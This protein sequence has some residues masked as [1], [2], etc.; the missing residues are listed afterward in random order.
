MCT[1]VHTHTHVCIPQSYKKCGVSWFNRLKFGYE[2]LGGRSISCVEQSLLVGVWC[3]GRGTGSQ[4]H[5]VSR[6]CCRVERSKKMKSQILK[7]TCLAELARPGQQ[8]SNLLKE[9][10][11]VCKQL[12][13]L[14]RV[15]QEAEGGQRWIPEM[16]IHWETTNSAL[17][18]LYLG[19]LTLEVMKSCY[20][21]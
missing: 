5:M 18:L 2:T 9:R 15:E 7:R 8:E 6:L 19:L 21:I 16:E 12:V 11:R 14:K 17:T 4:R 20:S 13:I 10:S 1:C 3:F